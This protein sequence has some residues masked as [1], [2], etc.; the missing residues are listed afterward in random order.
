M[1]HENRERYGEYNQITSSK[2]KLIKTSH[3]FISDHSQIPPINPK[4]MSYEKISDKELIFSSSL[5]PCSNLHLISSKQTNQST[6]ISS[7]LNPSNQPTNYNSQSFQH[8]HFFQFSNQNLVCS[9]LLD[10]NI[11]E[12]HI[13]NLHP[14]KSEWKRKIWSLLILVVK[15]S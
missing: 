3:H 6:K 15:Q 1:R 4:T 13:K 14:K 11:Q 9:K 2:Y 5:S 10:L 12:F 7:N 8:N